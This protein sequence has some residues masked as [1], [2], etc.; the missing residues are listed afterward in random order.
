MNSEIITVHNIYDSIDDVGV[1]AYANRIIQEMGGQYF[2]VEADLYDEKPESDQDLSKPVQF[3]KAVEAPR[4]FELDAMVVQYWKYR[5]WAVP[6][7]LAWFIISALKLKASAMNLGLNE[8]EE[9]G[10]QT[11][12][13]TPGKEIFGT[14][15]EKITEIPATLMPVVIE[16]L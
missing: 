5:I 12:Y 10:K 11:V 8:Y 2:Y 9:P 15:I 3:I 6:L 4:V 14:K 7:R 13:L 16:K 1:Q